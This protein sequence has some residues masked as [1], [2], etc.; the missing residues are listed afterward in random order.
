MTD[1]HRHCS[2]SESTTGNRP[3]ARTPRDPEPGSRRAGTVLGLA[4]RL[5][6]AA[7]AS[8]P[9]AAV[10]AILVLM[11]GAIPLYTEFTVGLGA[12]Y[13]LMVLSLS[14]LASWTGIWS[15]GHPALL[16]IGAYAV[17]YGS[18]ARLVPAAHDRCSPSPGA[19]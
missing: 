4:P 1:D 5:A 17:A 18:V 6:V 11:S 7:A 14:L 2:A 13:A 9:L 12:V 19:R 16:A 3:G 15:I 10:V 8:G